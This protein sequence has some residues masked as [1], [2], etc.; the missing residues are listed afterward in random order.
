MKKY[1]IA[2]GR[3]IFF[4]VFLTLEIGSLAVVGILFVIIFPAYVIGKISY[5]DYV[6][7]CIVPLEMILKLMFKIYDNAETETWN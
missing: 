5:Q 7:A 6:S 4:P 2:A 1:L 3:F